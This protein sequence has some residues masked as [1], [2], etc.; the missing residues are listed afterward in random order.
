MPHHTQQCH[1]SILP[2]P[3]LY[4]PSPHHVTIE[5]IDSDVPRFDLMSNTVTQ[6]QLGA[7]LQPQHQPNPNPTSDDS[8]HED[9][10]NN[11]PVIT[12]QQPRADMLNSFRVFGSRYVAFILLFGC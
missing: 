12:A 4:L 3:T 7:P 9:D 2:I 10:N 11:N 5:L 6:G 1:Y 8:S